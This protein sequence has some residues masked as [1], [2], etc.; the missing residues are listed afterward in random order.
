MVN[1]SI[2]HQKASPIVGKSSESTIRITIAEE[3]A[4]VRSTA[5]MLPTTK[6]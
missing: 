5:L 2:A 3:N 1:V 6:R 4:I